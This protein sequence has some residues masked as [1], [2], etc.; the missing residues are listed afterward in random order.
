LAGVQ[1]AA[2]K[3]E[4]E[5]NLEHVRLDSLRVQMLDEKDKATELT[6]QVHS[7]MAE[8]MDLLEKLT[9]TELLLSIATKEG[10]D[11]CLRVLAFEKDQKV[12]GRER[13]RDGGKEREGEK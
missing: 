12:L 6:L 5:A 1:G 13:R 2:A 3:F 4:A 11:T 7:A 10:Q 8:N 9:N